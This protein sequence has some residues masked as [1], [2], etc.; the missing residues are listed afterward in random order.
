MNCE[1]SP[2]SQI[3]IFKS[4]DLYIY[5]NIDTNIFFDHLHFH[6]FLCLAGTYPMFR[7]LDVSIFNKE[8]KKHYISTTVTTTY[9][10]IFHVFDLLIMLQLNSSM[11]NLPVQL[12]G[13]YWQ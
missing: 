4:Y 6:H 10:H 13:I 12:F 2:C 9:R 8:V 7:F 5:S 11:I 1:V 3:K